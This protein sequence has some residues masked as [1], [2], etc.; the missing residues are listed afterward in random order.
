MASCKL[1]WAAVER[2][3]ELIGP[4][5]DAKARP[6]LVHGGSRPSHRTGL[7]SGVYRASKWRR[8]KIEVAAHDLLQELDAATGIT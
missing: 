6:G 3:R 8:K 4:R 5:R 1:N 7:I 2:R